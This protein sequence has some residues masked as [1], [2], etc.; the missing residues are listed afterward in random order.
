MK[1]KIA[2]LDIDTQY[3]FMKSQGRLYVP[4]AEQ[5]V[6]NLKR[7]LKLAQDE[8]IQVISSLD[9]HSSDDPEFNSFPP[10][11]VDGTKGHKKIKDTLLN[12]R[13]QIFITKHSIDIFSNPA[14]KTVLKSYK[15]VY[16]FGV[17]LDYCVKAACLGL[18]MLGKKTYLVIDATKAV[19][20]RGK[21]STLRLL[22][23]KGVIF[24]NTEETIKQL[25]G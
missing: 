14:I 17:A 1:N 9:T 6:P 12:N 8:N 21:Q 2:F 19:S 23:Q 10:H 16:V 20:E 13:R 3:D 24:I 18:I 7:L 25:G 11:C 5:I 22:K 4:G 15:T